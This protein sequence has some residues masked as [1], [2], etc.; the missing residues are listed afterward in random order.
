MLYVLT[1]LACLAGQPGAACQTVEIVWEGTPHQCMLFG[2][3]AVARWITEHPGLEAPK[4]YRCVP[5]R[6]I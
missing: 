4:G 1:F 6:E 3:L 2:Q 5:G